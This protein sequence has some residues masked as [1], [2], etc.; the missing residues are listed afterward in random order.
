MDIGD[1]SPSV[2]RGMYTLLPTPGIVESL[3][4]A[5]RSLILPK[6]RQEKEVEELIIP[7]EFKFQIDSRNQSP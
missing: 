1:S 5:T 7:F 3:L 4:F 6:L 2:F